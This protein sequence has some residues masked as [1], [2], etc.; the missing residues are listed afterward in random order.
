[1]EWLLGSCG[2]SGTGEAGDGTPPVQRKVSI[3]EAEIN[4]LLIA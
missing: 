3:L 2:I 1:M 4:P